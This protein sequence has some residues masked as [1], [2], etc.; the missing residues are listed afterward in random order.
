[1]LVGRV[2]FRPA[3]SLTAFVTCRLVLPGM[4]ERNVHYMAMRATSPPDAFPAADLIVR[5]AANP[6]APDL[7]TRSLSRLAGAWRPWSAR[8]VVQLWRSSLLASTPP[9]PL[10][11][12]WPRR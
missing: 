9:L 6:G 3:Q 10:P 2:D 5:H 12:H 7:T 1:M 8:A 11:A 4:G